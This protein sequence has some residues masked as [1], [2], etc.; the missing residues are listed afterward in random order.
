MSDVQKDQQVA[1]EEAGSIDAADIGDDHDNP[2]ARCKLIAALPQKLERPIDVLKDM[3]KVN[4]VRCRPALIVLKRSLV[5]ISQSPVF[6]GGDQFRTVIT[7][8]YSITIL[9][10]NV[11]RTTGATTEFTDS[12]AGLQ[13]VFCQGE[14]LF[15][16]RALPLEV[17][18]NIRYS[19]IHL[20]KA[21]TIKIFQARGVQIGINTNG[22]ARCTENE[23]Q[24]QPISINV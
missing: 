6:S 24:K 16:I 2:A 14:D 11:E 13:P 9:L 10:E 7:A 3:V 8:S 20:L 15:P 1:G 4:Q 21:A 19:R 23:I 17:A 22:A 18:L 12:A 5:D